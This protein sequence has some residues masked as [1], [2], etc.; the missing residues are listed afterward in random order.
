LALEWLYE[1]YLADKRRQRI[2]SEYEPSYFHW[3][4]TLLEKC[5]PTLDAKDRILT[6]LLSEAPELN[7]RTIALVKENLIAVPERFVSC[8]STLRNLV[9]N[10]PTV[11]FQALDV[12]L[13]LCIN[14][15]DKI[16]RTSIVAVKKWNPN[17][18]KINEKVEAF[19]TEALF[20]LAK[21]KEMPD[22]DM[23]EETKEEEEKKQEE[24]S[25]ADQT[26]EKKDDVEMEEKED[27]AEED[28][29]HSWNEKDVVRHAELFFV[30]CTKNPNLLKE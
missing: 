28:D 9:S 14:P 6:K 1:E 5:I 17:Q 29:P 4:H 11:R 19:S 24:E 8:V 30:L 10:R 21:E 12:L 25:T 27:K 13:D 15:N 26:D 23:S 3:F 16:R 2:D 22:A 7:D 18:H 20:V